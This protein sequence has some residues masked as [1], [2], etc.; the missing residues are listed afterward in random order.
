MY[1][2][3]HEFIL[4]CGLGRN[5]VE[6]YNIVSSMNNK[7]RFDLIRLVFDGVMNRHNTI[8]SKM[9]ENIDEKIIDIF[10]SETK[11]PIYIQ[12]FPIKK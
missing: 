11:E 6:K 1:L 10:P 9:A 3:L 8:P 5:I 4:K 2:P 12:H 7:M